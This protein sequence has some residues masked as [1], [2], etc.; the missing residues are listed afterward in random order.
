MSF[1]LFFFNDTA[2]TE[3]YTLSLHDA[4]PICHAHRIEHAPQ[5][6]ELELE[7]FQH[8]LLTVDGD[9]MGQ[10]DAQTVLDIAPRLAQPGAEII[11]AASVDPWVMGRPGVESGL[12]DLRGKQFGQGT[13]G[14]FLPAGATGEIDVG[15]HGKPYAREHQLLREDLFAVQPHGF[16][17]PQPGFDPAFAAGHAVV[18]ENPL[19]PLPTHVE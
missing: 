6:V 4:L 2:T 13:A 14:C 7:D 1:F 8:P 12:V 3:I 5:Y 19:Q 16:A 11:V 15:V 18:V 9:V 17:Q 10:G